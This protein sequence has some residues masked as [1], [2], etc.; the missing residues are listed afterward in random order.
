MQLTFVLMGLMGGLGI[1]VYGMQLTSDGLQKASAH[2]MKDVLASITRNRLLA[3]VVGV[4]I[5]VLLQSSSAATVLLVGLVNASMMT[6]GQALGVILGSAV[7]TTLTVQL[8]AFKVTDYALW[9]V[10]LGVPLKLFA[11]EQRTRNLGQAVLGFGF[12]FY[13]MSLMSQSMEPLRSY[14][15]FVEMLVNVTAS[16]LLTV[17]VTTVFTAIVQS[18][19]ASIALGMS[20]ASQGVIGFEATVPMV[21]GANIGTTATALLSSLAS[22]RAAKR[23]ALAHLIFKVIGVIIFL[24]FLGLFSQVVAMTSSDIHRQIANGHSIFNIVNLLIF[25]PFTSHFGNLMLKILPDTG[26]QERAAHYLDEAVLEVPELAIDQ[27]KSEILRMAKV[28]RQDVLPHLTEAVRTGDEKMRNQLQEAELTLDF[29]YRSITRYLSRLAQGNLSEG[30]SEVQVK[31]LYVCNDL[32]HLGD[33][34]MGMLQIGQKIRREGLELSGEGWDEI[35]MMHKAITKNFNNAVE[36]FEEEDQEKARSVIH[37][38]PEIVR[39][40]KNLRYSHFHRLQENEKSLETSSV[41]LDLTNSLLRIN[42]HAISIAQATM[43]II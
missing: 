37:L 13:G 31:M 17:L 35:E 38:N 33:V 27:A 23:V 1:F 8:I 5:T 30:Q 14:P 16:P 19:A 4:V 15:G 34:M 2:R 28:V 25:L 24:P 20:L 11:K 7:G 32:E 22:S 6:L 12:I 42:S 26:T 29:L 36:A 40:E 18:S 21:L 43:G 39:M 3:V 9:M 10:A 41:H